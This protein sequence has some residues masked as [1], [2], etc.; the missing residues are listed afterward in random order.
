M[1][2][3]NYS[4]VE[5]EKEKEKDQ[6]YNILIYYQFFGSIEK[7][8]ISEVKPCFYPKPFGVEVHTWTFS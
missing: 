6:G 1:N 8:Q 7:I 4:Y 5:I 2:W 3:E